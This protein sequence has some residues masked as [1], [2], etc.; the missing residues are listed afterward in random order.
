[1]DLK[2]LDLTF[3]KKL[4]DPKLSGDL[5]AF[6]EKL[7][8]N[9][10]QTVLLA[11]GIA[12]AMAGA[13]GLFTTIQVKQM[14]EL[15]AKLKETQALK[16]TVPVI[17]DVAVDSAEVANFSKELKD[18][19]KNLDITQSESSITI[20][21]NSTANFGQFREAVGHV[22]NGG[23]GWRV[24]LDKLCV[25]RECDNNQKLGAVLRVNKVSVESPG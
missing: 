10:G 11:A 21:S 4:A 18:I 19:Y 2:S 1:M 15:R 8:H 16:P 24:T 25:G 20:T 6:L 12:W 7:P 9:A 22:Q 14:T 3:L 23:V 17:K 5:N 13:L